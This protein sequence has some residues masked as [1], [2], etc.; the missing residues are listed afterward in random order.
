[1]RTTVT[2]DDELVARATELTGTTER[3]ALLRQSLETLIRVESAKRLATLGGTDRKAEAAPAAA[4]WRDVI[5]VA[6]SVWLDHV[7]RP[8]LLWTRDKRLLAACRDVGIG[9][10]E[11]SAG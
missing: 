6:M 1:M 4:G 10:V 9:C 11:E 7:H 2:L 8:S 3:V 5:L